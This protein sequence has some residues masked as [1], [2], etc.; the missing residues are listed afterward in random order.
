MRAR[1]ALIQ[2]PCPGKAYD[3][4]GELEQDAPGAPPPRLAPL[5]RKGVIR[6]FASGGTRSL[7]P[8]SLRLFAL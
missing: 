2:E 6:C 7:E 3:E 4:E 1:D 8:R 5:G